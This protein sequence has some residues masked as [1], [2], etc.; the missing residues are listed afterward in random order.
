MLLKLVGFHL[1]VV[2]AIIIT[3]RVKL[4]ISTSFAQNVNNSNVFYV[5]FNQEKHYKTNYTF[6]QNFV[7]MSILINRT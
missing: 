6:C 5:N 2:F 4:K 7:K 3:L 1:Y